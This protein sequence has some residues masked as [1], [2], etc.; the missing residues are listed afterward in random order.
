MCT[1]KKLQHF[2]GKN[3]VTLMRDYSLLNESDQYSTCIND[4]IC[5]ALGL[6]FVHHA[7]L[8]SSPKFL[9]VVNNFFSD[10]LCAK[11]FYLKE[12]LHEYSGHGCERTRPRSSAENNIIDSHLVNFDVLQ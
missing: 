5:T 10:S 11:I 6:K 4:V 3:E 7:H 12:N 9:A 2:G 1:L 8:V